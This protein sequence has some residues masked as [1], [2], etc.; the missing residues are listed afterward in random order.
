MKK[1]KRVINRGKMEHRW[2]MSESVVTGLWDWI[3]KRE[4]FHDLMQKGMI[5]GGFVVH[6]LKGIDSICLK[7]K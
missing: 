6:Y 4:I 5:L 3:K 7:G 1:E 2:I